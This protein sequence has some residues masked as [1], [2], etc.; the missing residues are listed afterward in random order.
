MHTQSASRLQASLYRVAICAVQSSLNQA[1]MSTW[2]AGPI[3]KTVTDAALAYDV[4]AGYG[5]E[6]FRG[7][8]IPDG[9]YSALLGDVGL[10]GKKIGLYGPGWSDDPISEYV[11]PLY[12]TAIKQLTAL[13]AEVVEDPFAGTDFKSLAYYSAESLGYDLNK[14]AKTLTYE[15]EPLT[16]INDFVDAVGVSPFALGK[17][18][19][20]C[21]GNLHIALFAVMGQMHLVSLALH[22]SSQ[23]LLHV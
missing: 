20:R 9:G 23:F 11:Q 19:N 5:M 6:G 7:E 17:P 4:M 15:G 2:N 1:L 18:L 13:G 8:G 21:A 14:F 10:A 22:S 3:A 16:G 12:D